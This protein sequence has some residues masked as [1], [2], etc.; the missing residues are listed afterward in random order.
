MDIKVLTQGNQ[1]LIDGMIRYEANRPKPKAQPVTPRINLPVN[2]PCPCG[3]GKKFKKCCR[4]PPQ[5]RLDPEYII[6][7][8]IIDGNIIELETQ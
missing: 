3:S 7:A 6:T 5:P 4:R 2:G 1:Q 8:P